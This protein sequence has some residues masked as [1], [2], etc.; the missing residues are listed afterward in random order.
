MLQ[1]L[2]QT[3]ITIAPLRDQ[4]LIAETMR[5]PRIY[6]HIKDDTCPAAAEF[7]P[8]LDG[9]FVYV[10]AYRG[11]QFLGLFMLHAHSTVLWEVHTCL[12]PDAWGS[13]ALRCT[14]ACAEW[15]WSN[16]TCERLIT[17]VPEGNELALRLA[18]RS[19]MV[20]YGSNPASFLRDGK[21]IAQTLL[22]MSK[23]A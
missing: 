13:T 22:G 12:L 7:E 10:G 4:A 1:D 14:E 8:V 11:A 17:A 18:K 2:R 23:G 19:G 5:H 21:L 16:T 9:P 20:E 15:V 3:A 6:P